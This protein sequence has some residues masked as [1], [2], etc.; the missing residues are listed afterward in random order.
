MASCQAA[1]LPLAVIFCVKLAVWGV[2][3]VTVRAG[4]AGAGCLLLSP[5]WAAH[6]K[7]NK[8]TPL[9]YDHT[10]LFFMD[11]LSATRPF[12]GLQV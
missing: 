9:A 2:D 3:T 6:A 11:F 12:S 4:L 8:I 10:P 5:A 1:K 7:L